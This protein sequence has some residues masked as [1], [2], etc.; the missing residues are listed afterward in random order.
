MRST[1]FRR[2]RALRVALVLTTAGFL[3]TARFVVRAS[4]QQNQQNQ[5]RPHRRRQPRLVPP[6]GCREHR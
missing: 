1:V 6:L 5:N 2:S 4:A 3:G